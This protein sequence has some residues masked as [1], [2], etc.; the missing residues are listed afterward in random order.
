[1][2]LEETCFTG[3]LSPK[4]SPLL[5]LSFWYEIWWTFIFS[6]LFLCVLK[7]LFKWLNGGPGCS[8]LGGLF[9]ELGPFIPNPDGK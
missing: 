2:L 8:S 1:M 5:I 3:S 6:N 4:T 7:F 9:E